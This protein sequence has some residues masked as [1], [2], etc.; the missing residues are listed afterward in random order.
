MI[1]LALVELIGINDAVIRNGAD[2]TGW[3]PRHDAGLR[4][5]PETVEVDLLVK[6]IGT[7]YHLTKEE[8]NKRSHLFLI[9]N[10]L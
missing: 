3:H 8:K 1:T 9:V 6:L 10:C 2:L 7:N 4:H 5:V